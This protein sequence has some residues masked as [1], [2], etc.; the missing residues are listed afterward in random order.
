MLAHI[1]SGSQKSSAKASAKDYLQPTL[2]LLD[3]ASS[4][5][6]EKQSILLRDLKLGINHIDREQLRRNGLLNPRFPTM[7]R[8]IKVYVES[9]VQVKSNDLIGSTTSVFYKIRCIAV[10]EHI[11]VQNSDHDEESSRDG[12]KPRYGDLM[13]EEWVVLRSFREFSTLHKFLKTQVSNSESSG[14]AGAK[15]VGAATG[16]ATAA[17]SI[18]GNS[19]S[20]HSK[21]KILIPSLSQT[22]KAV[23]IGSTKKFIEKRREILNDYLTYLFSPGNLLNRCPELLRFVG[24]YD[25]LPAEV[26]IGASTLEGFTDSLGRCEMT[27]AILQRNSNSTQTSLSSQSLSAANTTNLNNNAP[28]NKAIDESTK[29]ETNLDKKLNRKGRTKKELLTPAKLAML[30]SIQSRIA[31][32]R[33]NQ[34]RANVFDLLRFTF[35]LDNASF[36]RNQMVSGLKTMVIAFSSGQDLRRTLLDFH[37]NYLS[38]KSLASW[39]K[40]GRDKIWPGGVLFESAPEL[41]QREKAELENKSKSCIHNCFPDQ[42]KHVLGSEITNEGLDLLH[43][44]FQNRIVLKSMMYMMFDTILLEMFPELD[45]ILTCSEVL[46]NVNQ[47]H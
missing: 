47:N 27:R 36:L 10:T 43:E 8:Q 28:W 19:A 12:R 14:G 4:K 3:F 29:K 25:P 21:R 38:G 46:D 42:L 24:A 41:S 9:G 35:D 16:L 23:S 20:I 32:V 13:R 22:S 17:L 45:D 11:D 34:V 1:K 6:R 33:L 26:E 18:G 39:I 15:I 7:L 37:V 30:S 5:K 40:Y 31:R 44:M 2:G